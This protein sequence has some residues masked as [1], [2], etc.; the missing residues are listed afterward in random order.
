MRG[1]RGGTGSPELW[2]LTLCE[3]VRPSVTSYYKC[4]LLLTYMVYIT[5]FCIHM[6]VNIT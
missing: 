2:S 4:S 1:M 6:H 3:I 5:T